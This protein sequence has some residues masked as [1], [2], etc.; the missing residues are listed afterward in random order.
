M[1]K[2]K[3]E[4]VH[5]I[6]CATYADFRLTTRTATDWLSYHPSLTIYTNHWGI[7]KTHP[8]DSQTNYAVFLPNPLNV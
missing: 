8:I 4:E 7:V 6:N 1:I 2:I 5:K 3:L